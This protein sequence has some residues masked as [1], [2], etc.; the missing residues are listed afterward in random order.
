MKDI[1]YTLRGVTIEQF[2]ILFEPSSD[3]IE[4]LLNI[5]IRLNYLEHTVAVGANAQFL[6]GDKVFM[7]AEVFC[8]YMIEPECWRELSESDSKDVTLPKAFI[9]SLAGIAISSARGVL[10]AKTEKTPFAKYFLPLV[11]VDPA[12][13]RD[14]IIPKPEI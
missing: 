10:C 9:N 8:H 2:A 1:K 5:P 11:V 7:V 12:Q 6:E 13:I 4:I 3:G 14:V